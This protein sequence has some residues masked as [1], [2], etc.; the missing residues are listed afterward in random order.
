MRESE[1][2]HGRGPAKWPGF[3]CGPADASGELLGAA[4]PHAGRVV[5]DGVQRALGACNSTLGGRG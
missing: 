4:T 5:S 3:Q 2:L 1:L